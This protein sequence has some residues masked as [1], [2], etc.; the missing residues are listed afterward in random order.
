MTLRVAVDCS[1]VPA[2]A[3]G[4]GVYT[5]ELVRALA[6]TP[7]DHELVV[8]AR[9][10]LFPEL[11]GRAGVTIVPTKP[12]SRTARLAWEQTRLPSELRR[13]DVDILH[14]P[15]H[16]TPTLRRARGLRRV[17]TIHDVTFLLIPARYPRV[18]RWYMTL[19]TRAAARVA[20]AIV[21]PSQAVRRDV[22]EHLGVPASRVT[23]IPEAAGAAFGPEVDAADPERRRHHEVD[24]RYV[25]SVGSLEP[26]KN[27]GR[28]FEAFA[29]VRRDGYDGQLVVVGQRAWRFRDEL[30]A[31]DR[32][33][34]GPHVRLLGYV[35]DEDLAA[36]YRGAELLAF[37]SLYEG[38][39]LPV[40]EAMA[41]GTPV[42]TSRGSALEEIAGDGA[43][44]VDPLDV[45]ELADA[46]AR[47]LSD[48]AWRDTLR[49]RGLA[50]AG[51]YSWS[52]TATETLGV[53][54]RVLTD[55]GARDGA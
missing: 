39:G 49:T 26:G 33:G 1:A 14:S 8:F 46:M 30:A 51:E 38:F 52:R 55:A 4:A 32:L 25:L 3:A 54:E 47:V 44:L 34:L 31:L 28:L 53:Y 9:P 19:L 24:G 10:D 16:H 6:A 17:V 35:P 50:R 41:S 18:R 29:R 40:L 42:V 5:V 45:T 11:I 12:R 22:V 37:P 48:H 23:V 20:D 21:V 13:R 2:R 7:G 15:H 27:R 43:V 36:L